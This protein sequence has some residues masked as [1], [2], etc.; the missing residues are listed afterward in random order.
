[1]VQDRETWQV[2]LEGQVEDSQGTAQ[3]N[4]LDFWTLGV[5][6]KGLQIYQSQ[7]EN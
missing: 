7:K 3:L 4:I 2:H 1:M 5:F 6:P